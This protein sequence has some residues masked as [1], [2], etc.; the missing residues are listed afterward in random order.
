MRNQSILTDSGF[1][2]ALFDPASDPKQHNQAA[3]IADLIEDCRILLPWPTLYEFVNT[4]LARRRDN[5]LR[6]E[7]FIKKPN[8]SLIDDLPYREEALSTVFDDN[9]YS[10]LQ[11]SLVDAVIRGVLADSSLKINYLATF[12]EKDFLDVCQVR[13]IHILGTALP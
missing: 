7:H 5:L 6:F 1:W 9:R 12:N 2:I 10:K 11:L 13:G 8:V 3:G 4:R